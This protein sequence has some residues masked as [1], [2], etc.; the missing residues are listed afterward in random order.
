VGELERDGVLD[1]M[2]VSASCRG[3]RRAPMAHVWG[4]WGRRADGAAAVIAGRVLIL[5]EVY[6]PNM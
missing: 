1:S 4:S 5:K 6:A 3:V 2:H